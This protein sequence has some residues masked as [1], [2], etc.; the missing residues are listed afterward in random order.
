MQSWYGGSP[1]C[2]QI[3]TLLCFTAPFTNMLCYLL[4]RKACPTG[5]DLFV[6]SLFPSPDLRFFLVDKRWWRAASEWW[7]FKL[8]FHP[9]HWGDHG[10]TWPLTGCCQSGSTFPALQWNQNSQ[11]SSLV[12][13]IAVVTVSPE[14]HWND[15]WANHLLLACWTRGL[16]T[17]CIIRIA[18]E[19]A[20]TSLE[21]GREHYWQIDRKK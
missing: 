17:K 10:K 4:Y 1:C 13:E 2:W 3:W 20:W 14:G 7:Q 11:A 19:L 18:A 21:M 6:S 9:D 12:L 8:A 16:I 15:R 5:P